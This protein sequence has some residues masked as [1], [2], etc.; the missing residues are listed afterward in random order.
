[1][2][3]LRLFRR[4]M[5]EY[6]YSQNWE[7]Q[8][9][10]S[11]RL[12]IWFH[13]ML[14]VCVCM[15][16]CLSLLESRWRI[17]LQKHMVLCPRCEFVSHQPFILPH[18]RTLTHFCSFAGSKISSG[19]HYVVSIIRIECCFGV[20]LDWRIN[21]VQWRFSN[22]L[23]HWIKSTIYNIS[24]ERSF[25]SNISDDSNIEYVFIHFISFYYRSR[26]TTRCTSPANT[27]R[28]GKKYEM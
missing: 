8:R 25:L 22:N 12:F 1:M 21:P 28:G 16:L 11:D 3:S 18:M 15:S 27:R 9:E 23:Y 7:K 24:N 10:R 5:L 13:R 14:N 26:G 6:K 19:V 2:S 4:W 17:Q 20:V